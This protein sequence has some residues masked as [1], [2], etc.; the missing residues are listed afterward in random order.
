[1]VPGDPPCSATIGEARRR[2][3]VIGI[4]ADRSYETFCDPTDLGERPLC[5]VCCTVPGDDRLS[6]QV[7]KA[8][9]ID[10]V[11]MDSFGAPGKARRCSCTLTLVMVPSEP[12]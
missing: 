3:P 1:M 6:E 4:A 11:A 12:M 10:H 7:S 9:G 2:T 8:G 5:K